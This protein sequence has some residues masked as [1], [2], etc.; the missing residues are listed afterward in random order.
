MLAI[1]LLLRVDQ[2]SLHPRRDAGFGMQVENR[3]PLVAEMRALVGRRHETAGPVG[4]A[5]DRPPRGS[6]ITT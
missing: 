5:R 2:V 6:T 1:K 4:R 3:F